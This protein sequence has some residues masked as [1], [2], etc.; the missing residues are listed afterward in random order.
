MI[1]LLLSLGVLALLLLS[2]LRTR[3]QR[4]RLCQFLDRLLKGHY[5]AR[6]PLLPGEGDLSRRLNLLA[7]KMGEMQQ[8]LKG[9]EER[10]SKVLSALKIPLMVLD[11][12][13]RV[14]MENEEAQRAFGIQVG[15][16][17]WELPEAEIREAI[18]LSRRD[19]RER[20]YTFRG[21]RW[22]LSPSR[23]DDGLLILAFHDLTPSREMERVKRDL[24]ANVSHELRTPLA[25]IK[26]YLEAMREDPERGEAF[27]QAVERNVE[28]LIRLVDDLLVLSE[29]E[30]GGSR[31]EREWVDLKE[32]LGSLLP[33]LRKRA[34]D[35]GI[36]MREDVPPGLGVW[37]DPTRL[38]EVLYNLLDNAIRFTDRGWVRIRAWEAPRGTTI[39]I[40]DSGIG[41]P[42]EDLGRIFERFYVVDKSRSRRTGG[43]GLGLAIVKHIVELHGGDI[44]VES[45]LGEGSAFRVTFPREGVDHGR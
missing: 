8:A 15:R 30:S 22:L 23:T 7:E 35:K 25:A 14:V 38:T 28:R 26:G 31:L 36:E 2:L 24:V 19:S 9:Q 44:E 16:S 13:G 39:E 4:R 40:S 32:L 11:P 43:T 21:R 6:A 29:L 37:A 5:S 33:P 34:E 45:R 18:H 1:P 41:I 42:K 27:L 10:F 20:E 12:S 17:F 3:S